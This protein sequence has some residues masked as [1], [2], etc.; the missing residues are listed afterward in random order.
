MSMTSADVAA[1]LDAHPEFFNEHADVLANASLVSPHGNRAV[2]LQERQLEVLRD[3]VKQLER[4]LA[5]LIRFGQ[6]ND[7]ITEKTTQLVRALFLERNTAVLP[8]LLVEQLRQI[9]SVPAAAVRLWNVAVGADQEY[10]QA[11]PADAQTFANSLMTPYCGPNSKFEAVKWL[12]DS[13]HVGSVALVPLR[14]GA[15]PEAFGLLVLGSPDAHRFH[16]EMGTTYLARIGEI[17]SAAL[18]RLLK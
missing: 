7:A 16:A 12:P 2:S 8:N 4:K 5:E 3:R 13:L 18:S 11:V 9:F 10:A 15:A 17:A 6:E 14:V 1:Y